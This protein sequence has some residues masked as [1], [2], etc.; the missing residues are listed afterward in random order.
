VESTPGAI[1]YV[2]MGLPDLDVHVR[3]RAAQLLEARG[4]QAFLMYAVTAG[5]QF[6][7]AL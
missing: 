4:D 3:H 1:G 7:T 5:Q 2:A 6:A